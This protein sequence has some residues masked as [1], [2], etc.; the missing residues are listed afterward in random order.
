MNDLIRK[1]KEIKATLVEVEGKISELENEINN[2]HYEE[3]CEFIK[4]F[5]D[6]MD[7]NPIKSHNYSEREF[8]TVGSIT[9]RNCSRK[10]K[11]YKGDDLSIA[12]GI[13]VSETIPVIVQNGIICNCELYIM[14]DG[15]FYMLDNIHNKKGINGPINPSKVFTGDFITRIYPELKDQSWDLSYTKKV[16][17]DCLT[18]R[19]S[20]IE[21]KYEKLKL[22]L[23]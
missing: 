9:W 17:S 16:L 7:F 23:N 22:E 12:K 6:L 5:K 10:Y 8:E 2:K 13:K 19:V 15:Q 4:E 20:D 14:D 18:N 11:E 3:I 21:E 1:A